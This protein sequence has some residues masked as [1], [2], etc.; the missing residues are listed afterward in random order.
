[1]ER[2]RNTQG[3]RGARLSAYNARSLV[4]TLAGATATSAVRSAL[5]KNNGVNSGGKA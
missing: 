4:L 5:V 1:M 2:G 3:G